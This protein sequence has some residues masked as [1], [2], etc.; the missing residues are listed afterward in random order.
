M[1]LP[2]TPLVVLLDVDGV[3]IIEGWGAGDKVA[4]K[5][6]EII[7]WEVNIY[8]MSFS[9]ANIIIIV[10]MVTHNQIKHRY[11]GQYVYHCQKCERN[12]QLCLLIMMTMLN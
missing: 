1:I 4:E 10:Y 5:W 6:L 11:H 12:N 3:I 2:D 9:T 8:Y 7:N